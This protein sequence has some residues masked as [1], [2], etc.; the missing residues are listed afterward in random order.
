MK[1]IVFKIL[2]LFSKK[3][4]E[5]KDDLSVNTID[6][7]TSPLFEKTGEASVSQDNYNN[8]NIDKNE[9]DINE[10]KIPDSPFVENNQFGIDKQ[11]AVNAFEENSFDKPETLKKEDVPTEDKII[12]TNDNED[13]EKPKEKHIPKQ[14]SAASKSE[15][16]EISV[17][18][19][20]SKQNKYITVGKNKYAVGLFWQPFKTAESGVKEI[21]SAAANIKESKMDLYCSKDIGE[22]QY[23]LG[24]TSEGYKSGSLVAAIPVS[25]YFADKPSSLVIFK[26]KEGWWMVVIRNDIIL[27]DEDVLFEN[28]DDALKAYNSMLSIP[29]WGHKVAPKEWN[30]EGSVDVD[31]EEILKSF[32]EKYT[33]SKLYSKNKV[34]L[35]LVLL[36]VFLG[37]AGYG[38]IKRG[39]IK[40]QANKAARFAA[41]QKAALQES[42]ENERLEHVKKLRAKLER[43]IPWRNKYDPLEVFEVC[44]DL[45]SQLIEPFAGWEFSSI[46]CNKRN[47]KLEWNK[48]YGLKSWMFRAQQEGYIPEKV[49]LEVN[50]K[51]AVG[52]LE[53]EDVKPFQMYTN[54]PLF[55][56]EK[57]RIDFDKI[58]DEYGVNGTFK[59]ETKVVSEGKEEE[60]ISQNLRFISFSISTTES[61]LSTL[62]VFG[63]YGGFVLNSIEWDT[64][65]KE[66]K[67]KGEV[68]AK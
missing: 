39:A 55:T 62:E 26:V 17:Q 8:I 61:I 60:K 48:N 65:S 12:K 37:F 38:Y 50:D 54:T 45:A 25:L 30:I 22:P 19:L 36:S 43:K 9:S 52:Y 35:L 49:K 13:S 11:P 10:Q 15:K 29:D 4:K 14:W 51:T 18:N 56:I 66:W 42:K 67:Y 46:Q 1:S 59:D 32:P 2:N 6:E 68:Y 28:E 7:T 64:K 41:R 47:I 24:S 27:P 5:N 33:L 21:K 63:I 16:T 44:S 31:L 58:F 53:Y 40:E 20:K 34:I 57:L 3:N 23:A